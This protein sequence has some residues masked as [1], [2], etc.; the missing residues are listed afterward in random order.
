MVGFGGQ[1]EL[2]TPIFL[3]LRVAT[4][5]RGSACIVEM[6]HRNKTVTALA[7]DRTTPAGLPVWGRGQLVPKPTGNARLAFL[8]VRLLATA[9]KRNF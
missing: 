4:R 9:R 6:V 8:A 2:G 5:I 3:A 7:S 1:A